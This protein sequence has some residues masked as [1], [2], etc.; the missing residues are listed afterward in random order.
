LNYGKK[1]MRG[2]IVSA[3]KEGYEFIGIFSVMPRSE[4]GRLK[5]G[6]INAG[7]T[8]LKGTVQRENIIDNSK[9]R[10]LS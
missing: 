3:F 8:I 2:F 5:Q 4:T 6:K 7:H 1:N 9:G 10:L